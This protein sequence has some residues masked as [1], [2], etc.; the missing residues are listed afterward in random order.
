MGAS[1][2]AQPD[3][4]SFGKGQTEAPQG[5]RPAVTSSEQ[6]KR[7]RAT[8]H[9]QSHFFGSGH[10]RAPRGTTQRSS[11]RRRPAGGA[12]GTHPPRGHQPQAGK[13]GKAKAAAKGKVSRK[14]W[15]NTR[16]DE[17]AQEPRGGEQ[18]QEGNGRGET[19]GCARGKSSEGYNPRGAT[20]MKQ[21]WKG[22][23]WSARHEAVRNR[24]RRQPE[25]GNLGVTSHP[26]SNASKGSQ[27]Q[28]RCSEAAVSK[29]SP[30]VYT[31]KR[32]QGQ[33]RM[34]PGLLRSWDRGQHGNT[35]QSGQAWPRTKRE[36]STNT[37]LR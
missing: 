13:G 10:G 36:R 14:A 11:L 17:A 8:G 35:S 25:G 4:Q 27:P 19:N 5:T 12:P 24:T 1:H 22:S 9:G 30:L 37:A 33:E 23:G 18:R 15:G 32:G 31:P 6:P 26:G 21:G 34:V 16:A 28:E 29:R 7:R 2:G 3:D 20:G